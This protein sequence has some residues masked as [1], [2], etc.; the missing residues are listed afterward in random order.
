MNL[1]L[2][3]QKR[4]GFHPP[5]FKR[6][7]QQGNRDLFTGGEQHIHFPPVWRRLY[8]ICQLN[9]S[10]GLA[11]HGR[12]Y[13]HNLLIFLRSSYPVSHQTNGLGVGHR[14][15]AKFLYDQC[16]FT[17]VS[18]EV[19]FNPRQCKFEGSIDACRL[20]ATSHRHV[21]TTPTFTTNLLRGQINQLTGFKR[22]D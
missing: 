14:G 17:V 21:G 13:H 3:T 5:R 2:T 9:Q 12:N 16:H 20:F 8:R 6:H 19:F 7:C 15:T 4:L 18:L 1:N 10:I 11:R 22:F